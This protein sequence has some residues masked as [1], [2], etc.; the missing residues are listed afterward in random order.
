MPE[1]DAM[2]FLQQ[3]QQQHGRDV[4]PPDR[5]MTVADAPRWWQSKPACSKE[6]VAF[7]IDK[8]NDGSALGGV[9]IAER[10]HGKARVYLFWAT[11]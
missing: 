8:P 6:A 7:Q 11:T 10:R 2:A 5:I 9:M 1:K 4:L 3:L